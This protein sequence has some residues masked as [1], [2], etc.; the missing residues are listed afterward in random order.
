MA[1]IYILFKSPVPKH[2][3]WAITSYMLAGVAINIL[4]NSITPP[5]YDAYVGVS[6]VL[7]NINYFALYTPIH[8]RTSVSCIF[9]AAI[10]W[11]AFHL[12]F[13]P[14]SKT[15]IAGLHVLTN[16]IGFFVSARLY[17]HRRLS[18]KAHAEETALKQELD[19]LASLDPLTNIKNRRAFSKKAIKEFD[20]ARRF[21]RPVS[22]II[23][24]IDHLKTINDIHGHLAGDEAIINCT[25]MLRKQ[26]RQQDILG[27]L[28]GDEFGI[29]LPETRLSESVRIG[30]RIQQ[31]CAQNSFLADGTEIVM[32]L[33][34][35]VAEITDKDEIFEELFKR[36]DQLLYK[37]KRDGRNRLA[38]EE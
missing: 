12:P 13:P 7:L 24:D 18:F 23:V 20:R 10:I 30:E 22:L 28:G 14:E 34:L 8:I 15:V 9:S 17:T 31:S 4:I 25:S 1:A 32:S 33:S 27:R 2:H 21:N 36:A 16:I 26:I 19:K 38:Y 35:G 3:D 29:M 37:A 6:I 5:N 11:Q